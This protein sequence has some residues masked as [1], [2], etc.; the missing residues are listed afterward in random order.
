MSAV[1]ALSRTIFLCRDFVAPN[2]RDEDIC[3][4]LQG[5]R[6]RCVSDSRNLSS[7]SGQSTLVTLVSLLVRMGMQVQLEIPDVPLISPQPPLSGETLSEAIL[8]LSEA[9]IPGASVVMGPNMKADLAFFLGDSEGQRRGV[10]CWRLSGDTWTGEVDLHGSSGPWAF[11][12]PVGGMVSAALA[13]G[14]AFKFAARKMPFR[15]DADRNFFTRSGTCVCS[16]GPLG[17]PKAPLDAGAVDVISAGA[18]VQAAVYVL[19]RLP[20][21]R[22]SGRIL[23]GDVTD[24][25]NINRNMLTLVRDVGAEKVDVV[26]RQSG[27]NIS[28]R[29][30]PV[31]FPKGIPAGDT[32]GPRVLVGVDDIP[33][34]WRVQESSSGWVAVSGTSHFNV[35][36]S[37]HA[38]GQPCSG[39]LHPVD[40]PTEVTGVPTVSFVSFWAGLLMAVRLVREII[41][42][43]YP[44]TRQHLWLSPLRMELPFSRFWSPVAPRVDCPVKCATARAAAH[45]ADGDPMERGAG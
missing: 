8:G 10:P 15:S 29:P 38:S 5:V 37:S 35:S 6:V 16:F 2:L 13:A 45:L 17:L 9:T 41:G 28:L 43:P 24:L 18:V 33:T 42:S 32:L 21:L 12:W 44:S 31:R 14:E 27:P 30:L 11:D 40:D 1:E 20:G 25:S 19:G 39:C 3:G 7:V 23:D 4:Y 22:M 36:S 34:R 26:T